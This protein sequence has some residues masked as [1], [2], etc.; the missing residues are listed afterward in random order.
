[1]NEECCERTVRQSHHN[2][3]E[4]KEFRDYRKGP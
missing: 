2:L 3:P 4:V 1:M